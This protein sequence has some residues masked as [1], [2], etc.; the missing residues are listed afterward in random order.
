MKTQSL[1]VLVA[2][3]DHPYSVLIKKAFTGRGHSVV[4]CNSA[5]NAFNRLQKENLILC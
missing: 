1:R 4:I 2:D 3:D 5:E